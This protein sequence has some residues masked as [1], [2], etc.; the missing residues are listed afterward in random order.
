[1]T[2]DGVDAENPTITP[3]GWVVY[4]STHPQKAGLWK[5][6]LDG[7][8]ASRAGEGQAIPDVSPD[9]LVVA[10]PG[11]ERGSSATRKKVAGFDP[12][13]ETESFAISPDGKRCVV[14]A[15]ERTYG[16]VTIEGFA[17]GARAAKP[18]AR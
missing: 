6:R 4:V 13:F 16:I 3:D 5:V 12:S 18:T 7:T 1:V 9:G 2:D 15:L 10:L 11:R 14:A 8:S 17:D